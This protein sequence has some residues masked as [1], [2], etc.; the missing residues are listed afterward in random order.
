MLQIGLMFHATRM[1]CQYVVWCQTQ[2]YATYCNKSCS[3]AHDLHQDTVSACRLQGLRDSTVPGLQRKADALEADC[4]HDNQRLEELQAEFA[5][6]EHELQVTPCFGSLTEAQDS[7]QH[8]EHVQYHHSSGKGCSP[9]G[10]VHHT[11]FLM[12]LRSRT[13]KRKCCVAKHR[14]L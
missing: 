3:A 9:Q 2:Y 1:F 6:L 5:L 4:E 14:L 13:E 8:T 7:F 11:Q 12:L 10:A